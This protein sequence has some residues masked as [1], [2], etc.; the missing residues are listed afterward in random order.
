[1]A[2]D[3]GARATFIDTD[4][5]SLAGY[6]KDC[7]NSVCPC[8]P[9]PIH[10]SPFP[11]FDWLGARLEQ[12]PLLPPAIMAGPAHPAPLKNA[13]PSNGSSNRKDR[14]GRQVN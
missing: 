13:N 5:S 11:S 4:R 12:R 10:E 6:A 7:S 14:K 8:V 1:M 3:C 2:N 9:L